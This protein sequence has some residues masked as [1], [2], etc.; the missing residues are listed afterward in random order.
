MIP[1]MQSATI[2]F[3]CHLTAKSCNRVFN[4]QAESNGRQMEHNTK[5]CKDSKLAEL[6][7]MTLLQGQLGQ[8]CIPLL[9]HLSHR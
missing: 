6:L 9:L 8:F 2:A 4:L 5:A 1:N 3:I 7:P